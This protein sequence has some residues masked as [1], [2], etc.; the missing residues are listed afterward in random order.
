MKKW[1]LGSRW[2]DSGKSHAWTSGWAGGIAIHA[3]A[4]GDI[5]NGIF[6]AAISVICLIVAMHTENKSYSKESK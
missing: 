3:F 6:L 1:I 2:T 4:K 5:G